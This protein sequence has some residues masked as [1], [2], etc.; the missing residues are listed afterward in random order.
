MLV[1]LRIKDFAIIDNLVIDLAG[2]F[3][4]FT[5]ETGAG[6]SIIMNA[7]ALVLGD[8]AA[9]D[10]V[11]TGSPGAEVEALFDV[12]AMKGLGEALEGAGIEPS[13]ELVIKRVIARAGRNRIYINGSLATLVTLTE[14]TRNL[15]DIYGQ[16]EHQSLTRTEEHL[17]VLDSFAGLMPLRAEMEEAYE[18]Y[19][20]LLR[21]RDALSGG[22][23]GAAARRELLEFQV[24]EIEEA[25]LVPG[26]EDE[27]RALKKRLLNAEKIKAAASMAER[28]IYSESGSITE[29]LG[30]VMRELQEVADFDE[31]IRETAGTVETGLYQ[32]EDVAA[33]LR[34]TALGVEFEPGRL[35][36]VEERLYKIG[37]LKKKYG[38]TIEAIGKRR[39][40]MEAE[41]AGLDDLEERLS[42]I[43][44]ELEGRLKGARETALKLSAAR[45][46]AAE[47][48]KGRME[49]ELVT[50]G[51]KGAVFEVVMRSENDPA[52]GGP[53]L[54][55]RGAERVA[56][57]IS[58]NPGEEIRPLSKVASGGEL[59]RI[60]LAI[61]NI[62]AAG[63]V[64][65]LVFDEIDTGIGGAMAHVVGARL[66]ALSRTHQVLCITHL[67]QIAAF[68]DEHFVVE[69]HTGGSGEGEGKGQAQRTVTT[70]RRLG[71]RDERVEQI[72]WMLGGA[73]VTDTTREHAR[74]LIGRA[75][76][77]EA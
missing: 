6:K 2:G 75:G 76:N 30:A 1:E 66:K 58:T 74:E 45:R 67:P 18:G 73:N 20:A 35:E 37:E 53:R 65:T 25:A 55:A 56:F 48:L 29:R 21:E 64:P 46:R 62:S 26:E 41:L 8:R 7:M 42:L 11:R 38:P 10:L 3:N 51:M 44:T 72:A 43:E 61:K 40:E 17:D 16:S 59:S 71:E 27:L 69:K 19:L 22:S 14:V 28:V 23:D 54:T 63:R 39:E 52:T 31:V 34:D 60:M 15:I 4:V 49:E 50:L 36:E 24:R 70:V 13:S 77:A 5:G 33:T 32:L 68:A 47:D 57:Y 9:A 12:S